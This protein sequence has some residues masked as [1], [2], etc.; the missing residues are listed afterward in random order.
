M[1]RIEGFVATHPA[2]MAGRVSIQKP[3]EAILTILD[4]AGFTGLWDVVRGG[5]PMPYADDLLWVLGLGA[6]T[7][8][9]S[10]L[11]LDPSIKSKVRYVYHARSEWSWPDRSEQFNVGGD[12]QAARTLLESGVPL[13]RFD[14]GQQLTWPMAVSLRDT[15]SSP[16]TQFAGKKTRLMFPKSLP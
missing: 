15:I 8:F 13:V 11:L 12:I 4:L 3:Y 10:A 2:Q 7:N 14:T 1:F 16:S 6:S 9:A 5:N